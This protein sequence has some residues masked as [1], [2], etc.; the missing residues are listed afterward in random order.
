MRFRL[1]HLIF[2][3]TILAIVFA[4]FMKPIEKYSENGLHSDDYVEGVVLHQ[5]DT[6][7]DLSKLSLSYKQVD[8]HLQIDSKRLVFLPTVDVSDKWGQDRLLLSP[9]YIL[10]MRHSGMDRI[11]K[12][13]IRKIDWHLFDEDKDVLKNYVSPE[14]L[15]EISETKNQTL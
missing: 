9:S 7:P 12:V 15:R 11:I 8:E 13:N 2:V 10:F 1:L 4:V 3:I 5:L 14:L 6:L